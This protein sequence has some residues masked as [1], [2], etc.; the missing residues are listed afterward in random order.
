MRCEIFVA[1]SSYREGVD[2]ARERQVSGDAPVKNLQ[3]ADETLVHAALEGEETP[4]RS[5]SYG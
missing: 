3:T 1:G 5:S 2:L 4:A